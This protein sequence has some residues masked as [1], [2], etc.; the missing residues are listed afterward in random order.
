MIVMGIDPGSIAT[1]YAFLQVKS[2]TEIKILEY[3]VIRNKS[4]KNFLEKLNHIHNQI[5]KLIT[6]YY[7]LNI[8]LEK[9]FMSKYPQ[10]T[11]VL[12]HVRG[13]IMTT[14][15][16]KTM[17]LFEYEP[18]L[19]KK[20][21]GGTGDISKQQLSLLMQEHLKLVEQPKPLDAA[22]ALGIAYCHLIHQRII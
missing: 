16:P 3:G 12:A 1:G 8:A 9:S 14:I 18:K 20:S 11:I 6:T 10:A 4:S 19:V 21:V 22:D 5:S 17:H 13:A 7:P 15:D 2:Y